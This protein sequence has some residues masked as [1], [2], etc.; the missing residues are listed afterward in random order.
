MKCIRVDKEIDEQGHLPYKLLTV[1][2]S[3]VA[4][5]LPEAAE[6]AHPTGNHAPT[7]SAADPSVAPSSTAASSEPA[8]STEEQEAARALAQYVLSPALLHLWGYTSTTH[9]HITSTVHHSVK[10]TAADGS[11]A[12][13]EVTHEVAVEVVDAPDEQAAKRAKHTHV[14][15]TT[16]LVNSNTAAVSGEC[17]AYMPASREEAEGILQRM[18]ASASVDVEGSV[19]QDTGVVEA[20]LPPGHVRTVSV[21]SSAFAALGGACGTR[22]EPVLVAA[23]DCEMCETAQGQELARVSVLGHDGRVLLES[24][25]KPRNPVLNYLT[26]YSGITEEMLRDVTVSL[27]QVRFVFFVCVFAYVAG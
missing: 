13:V 20:V 16:C 14:P 18:R 1:P 15:E 17:S 5:L 6:H 10:T 27:E 12:Q 3:K 26:Q 4:E 24:L 2:Y 22:Y 25:V 9:H 7:G 8:A 19:S 11:S 23:V 21:S